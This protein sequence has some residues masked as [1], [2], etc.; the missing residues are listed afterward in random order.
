MGDVGL[1]DP[2]EHPFALELAGKAGECAPF[3]W[4]AV[5]SVIEAAAGL[6]RV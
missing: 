6:G 3:A 2:F 5:S 1:L 4:G